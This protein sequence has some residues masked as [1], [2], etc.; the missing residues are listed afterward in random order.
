MPTQAIYAL[1]A[2]MQRTQNRNGTLFTLTIPNIVQP[3]LKKARHIVVV[4]V[5][6]GDK[7]RVPEPGLALRPISRILQNALEAAPQGPLDVA[8]DLIEERIGADKRAG[9]FHR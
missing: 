2:P 6:L 1:T 7:T 4:D 3:F 9:R 5:V 8:V